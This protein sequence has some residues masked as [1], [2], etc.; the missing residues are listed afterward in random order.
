VSVGDGGGAFF[1]ERELEDRLGTTLVEPDRLELLLMEV[2]KARGD[3][4]PEEEREG[5]LSL[6]PS[7]RCME[8]E[9]AREEVGRR[10][11]CEEAKGGVLMFWLIKGEEEAITVAEELDC[12]VE[13]GATT[14]GEELYPPL[15]SCLSTSKYLSSSSIYRLSASSCSISN[16]LFSS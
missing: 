3:I 15:F 2:E 11:P 14:A 6:L 8:D 9:E 16:L 1:I 4:A 12:A 10:M 7:E 13:W 5:V